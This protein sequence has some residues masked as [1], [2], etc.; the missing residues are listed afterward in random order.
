MD[1]PKK[2]VNNEKKPKDFGGKSIRERLE[3]WGRCQRGA[4]GGRMRA[5]ETR[6]VSPY[7]GQGYKCMT[8]VVC[9]ILASAATGDAGWHNSNRSYLDF[10]DSDIVTN[11]WMQ[12]SDRQKTLLKLTYALNSPVFVICRK[13]DIRV[14]PESHF[15]RELKSAENIIQQIIDNAQNKGTIL[16]NSIPSAKMSD[17]PKL[18]C[19]AVSAGN[20]KILVS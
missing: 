10:T 1:Q 7:G 5:K 12:M 2:V 11:A 3:N 13:L 17:A 4:S 6:S 18:G 16:C 20:E 14:W 19:V 8:A 15:R 9:N